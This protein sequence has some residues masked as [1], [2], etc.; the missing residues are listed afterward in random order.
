MDKVTLVLTTTGLLPVIIRKR[1]TAYIYTLADPRTEEVRYVGKTT[2]PKQR[3][4]QI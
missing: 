3:R 1:M 2:N 4:K